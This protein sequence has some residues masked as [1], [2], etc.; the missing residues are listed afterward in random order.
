MGINFDYSTWDTNYVV[1]FILVTIA[2]SWILP[3]A[4]LLIFRTLAKRGSRRGPSEIP[5][6]TDE[7]PPRAPL[8]ARDARAL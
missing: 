8:N 1:F 5:H 3:A 6:A 4:A 2:V 7:T